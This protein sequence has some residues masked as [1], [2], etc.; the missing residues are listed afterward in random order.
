MGL[1]ETYSDVLFE[2]LNNIS[3]FIDY[4]SCVLC[5]QKPIVKMS[6]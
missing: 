2:A 6:L 4:N 1:G 5:G 3:G